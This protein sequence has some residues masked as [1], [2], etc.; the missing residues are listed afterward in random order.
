[1]LKFAKELFKEKTDKD[2]KNHRATIT[3]M[4]KLLL[5]FQTE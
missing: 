3:A 2:P 5:K 4:K 1:M